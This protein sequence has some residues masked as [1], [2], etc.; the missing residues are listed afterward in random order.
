M[1]PGMQAESHAGTI[2]FVVVDCNG[3]HSKGFS[4]CTVKADTRTTSA[5]G[6]AL[7]LAAKFGVAATTTN[8]SLIDVYVDGT[9]RVD[10]TLPEFIADFQRGAL[11]GFKQHD[12]DTNGHSHGDP[13]SSSGSHASCRWHLV[14]R[15]C[16]NRSYQAAAGRLIHFNE[17]I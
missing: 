14:R 17:E 10:V 4:P 9:Q 15:E 12:F 2:K 11:T 3:K 5:D 16:S 7:S 6:V 13:A 1:L 8:V